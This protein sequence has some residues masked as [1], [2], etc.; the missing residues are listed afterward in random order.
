MIDPVST[1]LARPKFGDGPGLHR[2]AA[3][4]GPLLAQ[5]GLAGIGALK[6]AGSNGKGSTA[7]MAEAILQGVGL[8]VGLYTSPHLWRFHE[9]IRLNGADIADSAL[10][11]AA[12]HA[13]A[14]IAA[15]EAN[16]PNDRVGSFEAFTLTGLHAFKQDRLDLL[17]AEAGIG[18]RLDSVRALPGQV[19]ALTSIDLEHTELL[20]NTALAI[21]LDKADL[22]PD[23]GTLV[24]GR[25][26]ED[27]R[28]RLLGYLAV[29]GI[30]GLCVD[31][32]A[33][34]SP[35]RYSAGMM[36][37]DLTV[38]GLS[39]T[40]Q[41]I[42]LPGPHQIDNA[43]LAILACRVWLE[44]AGRW[45]GPQAYHQAVAL[46]LATVENPGRL[47]KI[48]TD[49]PTYIDV[50]HTP[51]AALRVAQFVR[52][53]LADKPLIL[54]TGGSANKDVD[55]MAASLLP[56]A[57]HIIIT[58]PHHR[59][60]PVARILSACPRYAPTTPAQTEPDIAQAAQLALATAKSQGGTL[61]IAGGLFLA[62]EAAEVLRGGDPRALRFL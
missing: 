33:S 25:L 35:P 20:G 59:G 7:R 62:V 41:P 57:S 22:C 3:L 38:Q 48:L 55:G 61:L 13:L 18:G 49:P 14:G 50:A 12:R 28:R 60:G 43:V 30:R 15:Y 52:S 5:S 58:Q 53:A 37:A 26:E 24:V 4:A 10:T 47:Q 51:D 42:A 31:Q 56:L 36:R 44:Q 40:D 2:M 16:Y 11:Y 19:V 23:G 54:L 45:P 1:L 9:R 46:A 34:A 29:R 32:L 39:W 8:R 17:I 27:I 21:A 6:I